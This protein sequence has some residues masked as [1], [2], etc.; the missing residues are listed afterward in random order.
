M[1]SLALQSMDDIKHRHSLSLCVL[2][3]SDGVL[4]EV[5]EEVSHHRDR[6]IIEIVTDALDTCSARQSTDVATGKELFARPQDAAVVPVAE[7][8]GNERMTEKMRFGK[9]DEGG[10]G[11]V[12]TYTHTHTHAFYY[13]PN[14]ASLAETFLAIHC[15]F[16]A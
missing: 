1:V 8:E 14:W 7:M 13:V 9:V 10:F 4:E 11:R 12:H 6:L 3:V 2:G 15:S 5:F 16:D